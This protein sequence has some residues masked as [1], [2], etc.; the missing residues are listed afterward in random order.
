M[1]SQAGEDSFSD[2]FHRKATCRRHP[3]RRGGEKRPEKLRAL[4]MNE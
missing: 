1:N 3:V 2:P 4:D